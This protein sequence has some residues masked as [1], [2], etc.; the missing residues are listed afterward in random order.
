[1][2]AK[3]SFGWSSRDMCAP[4]HRVVRSACFL[5]SI[6][7]VVLCWLV[8]VVWSDTQF[9]C[10]RMCTRPQ[11]AIFALLLCPRRTTTYDYTN[12]GRAPLPTHNKK[13]GSR[14]QGVARHFSRRSWQKPSAVLHALDEMWKRSDGGPA[15]RRRAGMRRQQR[16][17]VPARTRGSVDPGRG[18]TAV[19]DRSGAYASEGEAATRRDVSAGRAT[20]AYAGT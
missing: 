7:S 15:R 11:T 1:M 9:C 20:E 5:R 8:L 18:A 4:K 16:A 17:S 2:P 6:N 12:N 19:S 14:R 10:A 3:M 13:I